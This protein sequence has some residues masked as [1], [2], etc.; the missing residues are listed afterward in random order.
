MAGRYVRLERLSADRHAD[1][2]FKAFDG[3]DDV[4]TYLPYGPFPD[5]VAYRAW[6]ADAAAKQD[7]MFFAVHNADSGNWEGVLSFL[8]IDPGAGTIELGHI[9]FSPA[10]QRRRA[11]T[12][13]MYLMMAR[14]FG[15]GYRRFEW[16]C[17]ALNAPSRRAAQRLGLSF[18]GVFRQATI[19]KGRNRDTA[20]FAAIDREWPD[21]REA[22]ETWLSPRNF[23]DSGQQRQRLCALTAPILAMRDPTLAVS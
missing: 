13:A 11:A 4:W 7:P 22:F 14:A 9:N 8:R 5:P 10:L 3:R 1:Q 23:D 19:V 15:L 21:L 18:E 20:W 6:V 17:D 16:K 12:E 2:L